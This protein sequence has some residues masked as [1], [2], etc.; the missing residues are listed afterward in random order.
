MPAL[1]APPPSSASK[2]S[3]VASSASSPS[4]GATLGAPSPA[5]ARESR[6]L[7]A[8]SSPSCAALSFCA[9]PKPPAMSQLPSVTVPWSRTRGGE[10]LE[11]G[12]E[13]DEDD[14]CCECSSPPLP[15]L[16]KSEVFGR[17]GRC[18]CCCSRCCCCSCS[19]P[20]A[21]TAS[22]A[23][24]A[25]RDSRRLDVVVGQGM[26]GGIGHAKRVKESEARER[27]RGIKKTVSFFR[28]KRPFT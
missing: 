19:P 8:C 28:E 26:A 24:E 6:V 25:A 18:C 4:F 5:T 20:E 1:L 7:P 14:A 13:E 17:S 21:V 9:T 2:N 11:R 16:R 22:T 27:D 10:E 23:A 15:R 3:S 12:R